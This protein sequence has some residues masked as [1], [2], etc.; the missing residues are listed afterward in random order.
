MTEIERRDAHGMFAVAS[1]IALIIVTTP[2]LGNPCQAGRPVAVLRGVAK[3]AS[4][5]FDQFAL[6]HA[7]HG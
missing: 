5:F 7:G 3:R 2:W 6:G 1:L 4:E